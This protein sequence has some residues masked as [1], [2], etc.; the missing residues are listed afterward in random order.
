MLHLNEILYHKGLSGFL[1]ITTALN[2]VFSKREERANV[3]VEILI[4]LSPFNF[5]IYLSLLNFMTYHALFLSLLGSLE[6]N[7]R[8][9]I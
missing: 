1:L 8:H 2:S 6:G 5:V 4:F 3:E 7:K 9:M